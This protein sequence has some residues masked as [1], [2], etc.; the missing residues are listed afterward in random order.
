MRNLHNLFPSYL[1]SQAVWRVNSERVFATC[2]LNDVYL[3]IYLFIYFFFFF[4]KGDVK[5]VTR[6]T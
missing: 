2:M 5:K 1:S 4:Q 3:F 6:P